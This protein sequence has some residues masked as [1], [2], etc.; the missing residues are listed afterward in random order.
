MEQ[1]WI[2]KS[3]AMQIMVKDD[4]IKVCHIKMHLKH[5]PNLYILNFMVIIFYYL[6]DCPPHLELMLFQLVHFKVEQGLGTQR[7]HHQ[8]W[9]KK[10]TK[11]RYTSVT[12]PEPVEPKL[13]GDLEPKPKINLNKHFLQSV[14]RMQGWEFAQSLISLKSNE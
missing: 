3:N 13:F 14:W 8:P 11:Y 5:Q 1:S 4:H 12:E 7:H 9:D 10:Y 2:L 6:I